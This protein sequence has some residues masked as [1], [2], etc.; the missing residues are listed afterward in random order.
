MNIYVGNLDFK[1]NEND[2]EVLFSEYGAVDSVKI[3][4]DKFSGRSKGFGFLTME[5]DEGANKAIQE[6][7]GSSLKTREII[8]NEA[9]PKKEN[10]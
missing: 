1:V 8:V 5:D 9:R 6:L 2:L 3:I 7:N 10:Y 4:V